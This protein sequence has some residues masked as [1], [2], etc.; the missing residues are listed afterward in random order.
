MLNKTFKKKWLAALRSGKY[1]QTNGTLKKSLP[2]KKVG[3]CC[4]G[5]ACKILNVDFKKLHRVTTSCP[6]LKKNDQRILEEKNV[7]LTVDECRHLSSMNDFG[8]S[9]AQ[10]ADYIEKTF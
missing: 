9:F 3:Y 2:N 6:L 10:I 5:V 8:E 7:G 4:I 1:K